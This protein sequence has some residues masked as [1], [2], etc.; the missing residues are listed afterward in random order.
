MALTKARVREILSAAGVDSEHAHEAVEAIIDGHLSSIEALREEVA[1]YK[2]EAEKLPAVQKELDGFKKGE[3][4]QKKYEA[5]EKEFNDY[6]NEIT[7]KET[8][9]AKEK[10]V[11]AYFE[12]KKI[13]GKNLE[14]AMRG[15]KAETEAVELDGDKIKDTATLDALVEGDFAGL[16][17]TT[18]VKGANTSTPP[19]NTG[20][21][22]M[23]R[24]DIMKIKDTAERQ[25]AMLENA[26]E[27]GLKLE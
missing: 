16:V 15:C 11:R 23:S 21:G 4:W 20:G 9:V 25:K 19:A 8:K 5:K 6:K 18:E 26:S 24:A 7:A 14:I 1:K 3:D 12:G 10:A 13:T 27:F 17:V 22:K 2:E